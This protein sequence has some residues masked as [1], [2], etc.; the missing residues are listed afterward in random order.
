MIEMRRSQLEAL[1]ILA[2]GGEA[3][4]YEYGNDKV[5]KYFKSNVDIAAKERKVKKFLTANFPENAV[6][7]KEEVKVNN[8]F[9]AYIMNRLIGAEDFHQFTKPKFLTTNG[10]TN[11]DVLEMVA[12]ASRILKIFHENGV[13]IGDISDFN[14]VAVGKKPYFIDGDSWGVKGMFSPDAYT[15]LFTCP[16][17]YTTNGRID[18]SVENE[19]YNFAV[20]AFNMLSRIHPFFGVYSKEPKMSPVERMKQR[21]S[22]LG[23]EKENIKIPKIIPSWKWMSP[24]LEH[25]FIDIFE[26]GKKVDITGELDELSGNMKYCNKHKIYYYGKYKEC[27]L[28]N[29]DAKIAVAPTVIVAKIPTSGGPRVSVYF[30]ANDCKLLLG[31]HQ[32]LS[33]SGDVVYFEVNNTSNTRRIK[34]TQGI[35]VDYSDDGEYAFVANDNQINII[36][37]TGAIISS[38]DRYYKSTYIIRD[39]ELYYV[40]KGSYVTKLIV[41]PKGNICHSYGKQFKPLFAASKTGEVFIASMYPKKAIIYAN[42]YN[43]E[44]KY[45]DK[46][47]EYAIKF[48]PVSNS[49]LFVYQKSN[50]KFRTMIFMN[51]KIVYDDDIINY[52]ATP[53]SGICFYGNTIYDPS[54]GKFIGINPYTNNAKEFACDV[55]LENSKLE[56]TGTGFRIYNDNKI[57][58]FS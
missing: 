46:I 27:P 41:T 2:E 11:K 13:L 4:I 47:N 12:E 28:C 1:P 3:I 37:R 18:F 24:E 54:N 57:Y 19:N 45:E 16:D 55:V 30:A 10:I 39:K 9:A 51:K 33:T 58:N 14:L 52:N 56:F 36:D 8:R 34:Y 43:F 7:P 22:I 21:I 53:L 48:D 20:L 32:Y 50:G 26:N 38:I 35:R 31:T 25:T 29:S 5:I 40:D 6:L 42:D 23:K 15:E 49:W 44:V 17:S